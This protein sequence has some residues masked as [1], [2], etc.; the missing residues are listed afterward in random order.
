MITPKKD[1]PAFSFDECLGCLDI[2]TP[3]EFSFTEALTHLS[4]SS[5]ECMH[6]I[7]NGKVF[8]L[9]EIDGDQ[10]LIEISEKESATIQVRFVDGKSRNDAVCEKI[11]GYVTEWFDLQTDLVPF[12]RMAKNDFLLSKLAKDFYGLRIVG[13]PDLFEAL[14]WAVMGQQ[15]NL[16]FAYTL[17]KRFVESFG[18]QVQWNGRQY[19]SF[20]KPSDIS[21]ISVDEL[22]KLQFTS[23][24]AEYI[25]GIAKLMGS[26]ELSKESLMLLND[27]KAA[28][29]KLLSIRGIGPWTAHYVLMRCLRDAT[30]FPI[31]DAGLQNALKQL[32][33]RAQKPALEEI[34]QLFDPWKGWEA[35]AVFYLWRSLGS[36]STKSSSTKK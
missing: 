36:P 30:A 21:A 25:L 2:T 1:T 9:I 35:Y 33:D 28:E 3:K 6:Y 5:L 18:Q 24:K 19:W 26:G 34:R 32:L 15:V 22:R 14:C 20:P 4:R 16:R 17:K 8:K 12:Y 10:I 27:F 11:T 31:G 7:E 29:Q 13:I 23:K